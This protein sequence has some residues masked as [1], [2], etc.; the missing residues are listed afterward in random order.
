VTDALAICRALKDEA[1]HLQ[2]E[3]LLAESDLFLA[4]LETE[5][6]HFPATLYGLIM[7]CFAMIDLASSY[8]RGST[9]RQSERMVQFLTEFFS[10]TPEAAFVAVKMW[11][12]ALMHTSQPRTLVCMNTGVE[13]IWLL[14]WG[15]WLP[16]PDHFKIKRPT[17]QQRKIDLALTYLVED[18]CLALDELC[19]RVA[20][21]PQLEANLAAL[22]PLVRRQAFQIPKGMRPEDFA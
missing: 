10:A 4:K 14:H 5:S 12:H 21:D 6:R 1:L 15:E 8:W 22:D 19:S 17:A 13:Y 20:T 2:R 3:A 18:L 11:R 16:R 9:E 7:N